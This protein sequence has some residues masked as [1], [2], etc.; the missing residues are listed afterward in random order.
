MDYSTLMW[1]DLGL[2]VFVLFLII[3]D[4]LTNNGNKED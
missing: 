1:W 3:D 4:S 2:M